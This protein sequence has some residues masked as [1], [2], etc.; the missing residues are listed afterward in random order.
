MRALEGERAYVCERAC[1]LAGVRACARA[2]THIH[3][4]I[5]T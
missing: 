4:Y 5:N 3:I 2:H 1:M